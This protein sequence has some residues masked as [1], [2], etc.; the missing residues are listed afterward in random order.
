MGLTALLIGLAFP[1]LPPF[2]DP[3]S[4]LWDPWLL[5]VYT[6]SFSICLLGGLVSK[7]RG[8]VR[9]I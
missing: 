7:A 2:I 5:G 3:D 1:Y 8:A 4:A 6:V 9:S